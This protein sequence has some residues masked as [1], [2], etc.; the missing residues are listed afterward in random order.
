[1]GD[2]IDKSLLFEIK[3]DKTKAWHKAALIVRTLPFVKFAP[4][5]L[6]SGEEP[7]GVQPPTT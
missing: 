5:Q 1:M 3:S 2:V 4:G 6:L 7:E